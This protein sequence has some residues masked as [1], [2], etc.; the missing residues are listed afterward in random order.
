MLYVPMSLGGSVM[1]VQIHAYRTRTGAF[2]AQQRRLAIGVADATAIAVDNAR[3]IGDLQ[4]SSR[5]KSEFVATMS[6]ELRT[7]LNIIVGYTDMLAE[8]VVGDAHPR[9]AGHGRTRAA[10]GIEL[11][12]LVNATLDMGRL[13]AG[14]DAVVREEVDLD[15]VCASST[16]SSGRSSRRGSRSAGRT[17]SATCRSSPTRRS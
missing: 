14:R 3:L 8:G 9:A 1:G 5:L 16:S 2:A 4:A 15:A 10:R 11:L 17:C 13:E 7:P 12:D 6:H